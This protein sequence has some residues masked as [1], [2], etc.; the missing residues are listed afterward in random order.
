MKSDADAKRDGSPIVAASPAL[1]I[2]SR[3]RS[4]HKFCTSGNSDQLGICTRK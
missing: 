3:P 4:A 1:A 2:M